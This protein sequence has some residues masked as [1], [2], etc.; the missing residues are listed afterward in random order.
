[1]Y[2]AQTAVTSNLTSGSTSE[3]TCHSLFPKPCQPTSSEI[4]QVPKSRNQPNLQ[5][6]STDQMA[7]PYELGP[8]EDVV[9][10]TSVAE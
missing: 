10:M 8:S 4:P 6:K 7:A 9:Y 5:K 2:M 1:M 3:N